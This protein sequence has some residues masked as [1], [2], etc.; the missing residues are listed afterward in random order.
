MTPH[1]TTSGNQSVQCSSH[2]N[3][4][5]TNKCF[6]QGWKVIF[7]HCREAITRLKFQGIL[8]HETGKKNRPKRF[9]CRFAALACLRM[10][11]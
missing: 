11:I 9:H 7:E 10:G 8:V 2:T 6:G 1:N 4:G 5:S 3:G